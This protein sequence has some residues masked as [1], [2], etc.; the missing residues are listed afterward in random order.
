[1]PAVKGFFVFTA[2]VSNQ[3]FDFDLRILT[4]SEKKKKCQD[5]DEKGKKKF[6]YVEKKKSLKSEIIMTGLGPFWNFF[7]FIVT[8]DKIQKFMRKKITSLQEK[9]HVYEEKKKP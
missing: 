2:D 3:S 7:F 5:S 1:M 6:N 8:D 4:F 9:N